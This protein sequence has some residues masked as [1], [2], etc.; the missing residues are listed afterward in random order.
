MLAPRLAISGL[1]QR[2]ALASNVDHIA[3][4]AERMC[5]YLYLG[6]AFVLLHPSRCLVIGERQQ[7]DQWLPT[8]EQQSKRVRKREIPE[9]KVSSCE[10]I[11]LRSCSFDLPLLRSDK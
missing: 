9:L 10:H 5:V 7:Q 4:H 1:S 11:K 2:K 8:A 3:L 6:F